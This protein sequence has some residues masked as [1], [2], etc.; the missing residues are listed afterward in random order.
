MRL[1]AC[2]ATQR[3]SGLVGARDELDPAAVERDEE[4]HVDPRQ[5]HGLDG[6]EV[7]R[8]HRGRLL[9]QEASPTETV[10]LRRRRQ[11]MPDQDRAHRTRRD[12]NTQ[13]EQLTDDP[14][15][16]PA[17]VLSG[18]PDDELLDF[19][20]DRRT[21]D[22]TAR[23]RPTARHQPLVP[24][25][26]RPRTHQEHR[27][28]PARQRTAQRRK[29]Y[30]ISLPKLQRLGLSPQDREL[31]PQHHDLEFLRTRRPAAQHDQRE[32]SARNQIHERRQTH[33]LHPTGRR[34]YSE[35]PRS[36][37]TG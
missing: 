15:V 10:S 23:I 16:A 8:K 20:S 36:G 24:T 29:Q 35:A 1:R 4:Q 27:P 18:E 32:Q 12:R 31:M 28:G 14:L 5:Q 19:A 9:A 11:P 22:P 2:W 34:R 7:T 37:R 3:P 21:S 30:S 6:Q 26:Q 33:D 17:R 25:Q 13:A